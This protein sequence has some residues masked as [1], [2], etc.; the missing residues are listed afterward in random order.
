[1][2]DVRF[3]ESFS[4]ALSY[5]SQP[6]AEAMA[7]CPAVTYTPY[8][9][10]SK[11]QTGDIITFAQFEEGNLLSET[12]NDTESGDE[13]DSESIMMSENDMENLDETEKFDDDLIST[14]TLH[15]IRD[16][17]QTHPKINKREARMAIRDCIK[18]TKSQWKGAL[19]ATHTM[20]K[21]LHRFFS[22]I[23]SEI[24]QELTN[25]VEPG[26]EVSHFIPE[27]RKFAEVTRLAENIRKPWLKA[28][29]KEI[30]NLI[31]N[32]TFMIEDPKD[33]EPVTPCME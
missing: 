15:D 33:G 5:T 21:G 23:V 6:Y 26:S 29:L 1:M 8:A 17:N 32:Q 9:T 30:K 11:E 24:L 14:E 27:P 22:T 18:Q 2:Y 7:I 25:F 20:V 28:T 3:D 19:R 31:N 4:S 10:T 12:R 13:S 16:G